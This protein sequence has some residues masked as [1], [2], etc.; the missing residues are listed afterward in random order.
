[1]HTAHSRK[2]VNEHGRKKKRNERKAFNLAVC[3]C[4]CGQL[5][6]ITN[7]QKVVSLSLLRARQYEFY[8]LSVCFVFSGFLSFFTQNN[9]KKLCHM[10]ILG[11]AYLVKS[12]WRTGIVFVFTQKTMYYSVCDN[13]IILINEMSCETDE[14]AKCSKFFDQFKYSTP[15]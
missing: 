2:K 15:L 12:V 9:N 13:T 10:N 7:K 1:M 11:N 5:K 4:V 3:V 14:P 8:L 6:T